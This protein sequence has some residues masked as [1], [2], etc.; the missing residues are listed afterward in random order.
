MKNL[1]L[2]WCSLFGS[3]L[4]SCFLGS[5]LL[6]C[7]LSSRLLCDLLGWLLSS[8]LCW[9][10]GFWLLCLWFLDSL[11][12]SRGKFERTSSFLTSSSGSYN[13]LG[14]NHLGKSKTDTDSS[15][16]SIN[17]VVGNYILEDS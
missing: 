9:F 14:S 12:L 3:W 1:L 11:L 5:W 6:S 17:L 4:L 8:L 2:L 10:L 16:R 7:F 13:F 15:L